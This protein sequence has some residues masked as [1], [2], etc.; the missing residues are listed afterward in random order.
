MVHRGQ[1]GGV[2]RG[3]DGRVG[4]VET[5]RT[6]RGPH[7]RGVVHCGRVRPGA[8]IH[9]SCCRPGE[10]IV[11]GMHGPDDV[12]LRGDPRLVPTDGGFQRG[13]TR[14]RGRVLG[15][16][17]GDPVARYGREHLGGRQLRTLHRGVGV[18]RAG[19][20]EADLVFDA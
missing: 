20:E 17:H 12:G 9:R 10:V 4:A 13:Q 1:D 8:E 3:E 11:D 6:R 5:E 15:L 14:R 19:C 2:V 16:D 7:R 18:Y